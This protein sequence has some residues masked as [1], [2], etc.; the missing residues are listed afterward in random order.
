MFVVPSGLTTIRRTSALVE[1]NP[2]R[3]ISSNAI[4]RPVAGEK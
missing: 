1:P 3:V 2:P 4:S